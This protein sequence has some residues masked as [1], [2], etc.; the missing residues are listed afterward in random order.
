MITQAQ[1]L[2]G[3]I[4]HK[5]LK[6]ATKLLGFEDVKNKNA[7]E[8]VTENVAIALCAFGKLRKIDISDACREITTAIV[9][10][11][12]S[13]NRMVTTMSKLL[14]VSRK[15]LHKYTKF[16]VN[17]DENDETSF[18][19][20]ICRESYKERMEEGI[21]ED[22]IPISEFMD[23]FQSHIYKYIKHSHRSRWQAL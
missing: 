6:R 17:I 20:L 8:N 15:K 13:I 14:H 2:H 1:I 5:K 18:C 4:K 3:L 16:R 22:D 7:C 10:Q 19:A 21:K 23:K 11:R 12:T 9:A